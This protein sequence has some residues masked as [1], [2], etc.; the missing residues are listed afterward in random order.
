MD[1]QGAQMSGASAVSQISVSVVKQIMESQ[2][3]QAN[4]L[5]EMINQ[6]TQATTQSLRTNGVGENVDLLV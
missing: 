1:V 3:G 5:I 2:Q 4:A 6:S